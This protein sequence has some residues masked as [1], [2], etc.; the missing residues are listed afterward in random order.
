MKF[1]K[2]ELK[3]REENFNQRFGGG[4]R[5]GVMD[6]LSGAKGGATA[7]SSGGTKPGTTLNAGGGSMRSLQVIPI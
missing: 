7:P 3:N 6:N 5:V 1:F 2:L 4:P